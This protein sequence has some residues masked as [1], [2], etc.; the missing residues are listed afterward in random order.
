[1]NRSIER[2]T[3]SNSNLKDSIDIMNYYGRNVGTHE[4]PIPKGSYSPQSVSV[5]IYGK[6]IL[7]LAHKSGI[8]YIEV[9]LIIDT[10]RADTWRELQPCN[11]Y[12][13]ILLMK[14]NQYI[15]FQINETSFYIKCNEIK[16]ST[17]IVDLYL[18]PS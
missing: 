11:Y 13:E 10:C 18:L 14:L 3:L 5:P 7:A 12:E 4:I 9:T 8:E 6:T 2:L 16:D 17:V 1:M 15:P